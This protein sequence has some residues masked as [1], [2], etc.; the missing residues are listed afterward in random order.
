MDYTDLLRH[1]KWQKKRLE[2]MKRDSWSCSACH[3]EDQPLNVHHRRYIRGRKPWEYSEQD[4]ITLCDQCHDKTHAVH[5]HY[6]ALATTEK[7]RL[8]GKIIGENVPKQK[9]GPFS[10]FASRRFAMVA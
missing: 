2:I 3:A 4:L 10:Y 7:T 1:P 6:K 5:S 9:W 8:I